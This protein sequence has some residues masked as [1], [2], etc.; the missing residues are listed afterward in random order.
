LKT[1]TINLISGLL[2]L[3]GGIALVA[4]TSMQEEDCSKANHTTLVLVD[5]TDSLGSD[6]LG[7]AKQMVWQVIET[8]PAY[9]RLVFKEIVGNPNGSQAGAFVKEYC[10]K[11]KP[12]GTTQL[13]ASE[14]VVKKEWRDF[15]NQICGTTSGE[16]ENACNDPGREKE[17]NSRSR[18]ATSASSP[19]LQRIADSTRLFLTSS[20]QSWT[21]VVITDWRQYDGTINLHTK[22]AT[23]MSRQTI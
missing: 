15:K 18:L 11:I 19:I 17:W 1:G 2:M 3:I 23:A 20:E 14:D 12:D 16:I 5:K 7:A 22:N 13:F 8:A 9:S 21:L 10:R 4:Y 6:A